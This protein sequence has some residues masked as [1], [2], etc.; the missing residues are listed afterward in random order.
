MKQRITRREV[1]PK[2]KYFSLD[3]DHMLACP[4]C[5]EFP[6]AEFTFQT[7]TMLDRLRDFAECGICHVLTA[8]RDANVRAD[9]HLGLC[10]VVLGNHLFTVFVNRYNVNDDRDTVLLEGKFRKHLLV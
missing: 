7:M 8:R 6:L 10:G 5:G 1:I 9:H 2:W 3:S 4:C